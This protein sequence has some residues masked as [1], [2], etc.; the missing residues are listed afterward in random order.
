MKYGILIL[1]FSWIGS[2][3]AQCG[4]MDNWENPPPPIHEHLCDHV[5][6]KYVHGLELEKKELDCI[7]SMGLQDCFCAGY[8][9]AMED[10]M[11]RI[12]SVGDPGHV[13]LSVFHHYAKCGIIMS[14]TGDILEEGQLWF[15]N[16]Y[17]NYAEERLPDSI[18]EYDEKDY[19]NHF[20]NLSILRSLDAVLTLK[21]IGERTIVL[22]AQD[23]K[24]LPSYLQNC[25]TTLEYR[26]YH[27]EGVDVKYIDSNYVFGDVD[28][29]ISFD[30]ESLTLD[31]IKRAKITIDMSQVREPNYLWTFYNWPMTIGIGHL[32][33][34]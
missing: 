8:S 12:L 18:P 29:G 6:A 10:T 31:Q 27:S 19:A 15:N 16:G 14:Y 32:L 26:T 28:K 7:D 23:G 24:E 5:F 30:L 13:P 34:E 1:F 33:K 20:D 9:E 21:L 25:N 2:T 22:E 11:L 4:L 3:S 17:N